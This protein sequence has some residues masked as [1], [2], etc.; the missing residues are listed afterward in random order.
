MSDSLKVFTGRGLRM[1][2]DL[3]RDW[4]HRQTVI[5]IADSSASVRAEF[6]TEQRLMEHVIS[7]FGEDDT[8]GEE[9]SEYCAIQF[10][11]QA[12]MVCPPTK[13]ASNVVEAINGMK[14]L[15]GGTNIYA[16]LEMALGVVKTGGR[17]RYQIWLITDGAYNGLNP[18]SVVLSLRQMGA[19][20][21]VIGVGCTN[22]NGLNLIASPNRVFFPKNFDAAIEMVQSG[23]THIDEINF[24]VTLMKES[25]RLTDAVPFKLKIQNDTRS[26][27]KSNSKVVIAAKSKFW[28]RVIVAIGNDV[29]EQGAQELDFQL[30]CRPEMKSVG[31]AKALERLEEVVSISL[32]TGS[33][34]T[35]DSRVREKGFCLP[36]DMFAQDLHDIK[37]LK[38]KGT[39]YYIP[40]VQNFNICI[41]GRPGTGK[42]SFIGTLD[43][44]LSAHPTDNILNA[45]R[46]ARSTEHFVQLSNVY[47]LETISKMAVEFFDTPGYEGY[48]DDAAANYRGVDLGLLL[49]GYL[50]ENIKL[51][52]DSL[53]GR[54]FGIDDIPE[55]QRLS[56]KEAWSRAIHCGILFIHAGSIDTDLDYEA[57]IASEWTR[58]HNRILIV[59]VS[60]I[61][62]VAPEEH[63][64][65]IERVSQTTCVDEKYI[66]LL[67]NYCALGKS[68][69]QKDFA[70]DKMSLQILH[71]ALTGAQTFLKRW[72]STI[73]QIKKEGTEKLHHLV[74]LP[75]SDSITKDRVKTLPANPTYPSPP[76]EVRSLSLTPPASA[77]PSADSATVLLK[78]VR[79]LVKSSIPADSPI[80][81]QERKRIEEIMV[82]YP[83]SQE[84]KDWR[85]ML[86]MFYDSD[87]VP[88]DEEDEEKETLESFG[89]SIRRYLKRHPEPVI[90][91]SSASDITTNSS[92]ADEFDIGMGT[93]NEFLFAM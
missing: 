84:A 66:F 83:D 29:L 30:E 13:D 57:K 18:N 79:K 6:T 75:S 64:A 46:G 76:R 26:V 78:L 12:E 23:T 1:V 77:T 89:N 27:I 33:N 47:R 85:R 51:V 16:A 31:F 61:D 93:E 9:A 67:K 50:P 55:D 37:P 22:R 91:D 90:P 25:N 11:D 59:V 45:N 3:N 35:I 80:S 56:V 15:G 24:R 48:N 52:R 68:E 17:G 60:Q 87:G 72:H 39:K 58:V 88:L 65:L 69:L 71:A 32:L 53:D 42:S 74:L 43:G 44:C 28:E 82:D 5:A 7:Q 63:P 92:S 19:L 73:D 4:K 8:D 14:Y 81:Q 70:I 86:G 54:V 38:L 62:R 21:T 41:L 2:E 40:P 20:I 10:S 34:L 49:A 36:L